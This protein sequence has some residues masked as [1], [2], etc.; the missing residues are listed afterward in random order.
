V[1]DGRGELVRM[2]DDGRIGTVTW[3]DAEFGVFDVVFA[4]GSYTCGVQAHEF[5]W[6]D[7]ITAI[8]GLA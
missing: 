7:L 4:D 6:V 1:S 5:E 2:V 3:G 8:A